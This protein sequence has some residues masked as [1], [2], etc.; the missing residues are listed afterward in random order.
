MSK[1]V[2]C[3]WF[4]T[5]GL[6]FLPKIVQA[7]ETTCPID[8]DASE[9]ACSDGVCLSVQYDCVNGHPCYNDFY[10]NDFTACQLYANNPYFHCDDTQ[11]CVSLN[12][13]A[14][15]PTDSSCTGK[16]TVQVLPSRP[17][18]YAFT[19]NCFQGY[20][21]NFIPGTTP[22]CECILESISACTSLP[23]SCETSPQ[24]NSNSGC[25]DYVCEK[26][27]SNKPGRCVHGSNLC[28]TKNQNCSD[29]SACSSGSGC[30]QYTCWTIGRGKS[31]RYG[32]QPQTPSVPPVNPV[33][34]GGIQCG[35]DAEPGIS[36]AIGCIH[37]EPKALVTDLLKFATAISG[38]LAFLLMLLGAFQM[39]TSA[40]NPDTLH[41]GRDRFTSAIIGL[42]IVI[43]SILLMQILSIDILGLGKF[44][45]FG[46]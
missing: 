43:F 3:L 37:T 26:T 19:N 24:C 1:I 36:T 41:A 22:R 21:T 2:I 13:P 5:I 8:T 38:G 25:Q 23:T 10:K 46:K 6:F 31:C 45:G 14:C 18:T 29:D 9:Q 4:L 40:G 15:N 17:K 7:Q 32:V 16:C 27:A 39:I 12:P 34:G 28:S 33:S 42:L 20:K 11:S 30:S 35:T 44:G